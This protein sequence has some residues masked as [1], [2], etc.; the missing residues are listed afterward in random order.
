MF[1]SDGYTLVEENGT[2]KLGWKD[3]CLLTASAWR[4]IQTVHQPRQAIRSTVGVQVSQLSTQL[5]HLAE[6]GFVQYLCLHVCSENVLPDSSCSVGVEKSNPV[7]SDRLTEFES[8]L[9]F[10]QYHFMFFVAIM[11]FCF[12]SLIF[13][14]PNMLLNSSRFYLSQK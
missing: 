5:L 4:P 9:H 13:F 6:W 2:L 7:R 3:L 12:Y 11:L 1:P 14:N 8:V 10:V